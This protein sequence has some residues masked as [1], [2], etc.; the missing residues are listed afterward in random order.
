MDRTDLARKIEWMLGPPGASGR[1]ARPDFA[2]CA[3]LVSLVLDAAPVPRR[4]DWERRPAGMTVVLGSDLSVALGLEF[5]AGEEAAPAG[6]WVRAVHPEGTA[7]WRIARRQAAWI[8]LLLRRAAALEA[9]RLCGS[10]AG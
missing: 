10:Q 4:E 8:W 2:R 1:I 5:P 7:H 3:E 9:G 6:A